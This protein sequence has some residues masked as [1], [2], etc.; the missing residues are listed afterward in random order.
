MADTDF[1]YGV[2]AF[3]R[4]R[5]NFPHLPLVN[6][7]AEEVRTEPGVTLQSRPGLENTSVSVGS[8]A[9]EGIFVADG[10]IDN[11]IFSI[12]GGSLFQGGTHL[13]I[14]DG[15][16]R[17]SFGGYEDFV[18]ANAGQS[19]W[20]WDG[21]TFGAIAF[22]DDADV[23]KVVVGSNRLIAIRKDSGRFYWSEPLETTI[24]DLNFA[25][26]E[27]SPDTLKDMLYLGDRLILFGAETI[28]FWPVT[29]DPDAPFAPLVGAV[30]PVGVKAT[31]CATHFDRGFA[32]I[33][34][35]NE[36]CL[37][38]PD[39]IISEPELQIKIAN[40]IEVTLWTFYVDDN[41]YLVVRTLNDDDTGE[42][43]VYGART[44]VWSE[45]ESAGYNNWVCQCYDG[46]YFGTTRN[47][48]FVRWSD[49]YTDFDGVLERRFRAW[50]PLTADVLWLNNVVLRT[51]PG[52]TPYI[53]GDYTDP[54]VELRT[55]RDGGVEWQP[56]R[57]RTLGTQGKYRKKTFWNSLGQFSYPGVLV[58]LRITDPV[59]FRVSA[60]AL[61]QPFGGR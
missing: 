9:V 53:V 26:A 40:S 15:T 18:F 3:E 48:T 49:D 32:W 17:P 47:G 16:G 13:G 33:T 21:T 23:I 41:E 2:S 43:W 29:V 14:I 54:I 11:N 42:T 37:N 20:G 35:A 25:E 22:P 19:I 56:W 34:D 59:P 39:T 24:D 60:L 51:N 58:E 52:T 55:S 61:N 8:A 31:G 4:R 44:Q 1:R 10:V 30:L 7:L 38:T 28:E 36:V 6:M 46:G 12:A 57:H 27:N 50:A 5:G 45:L